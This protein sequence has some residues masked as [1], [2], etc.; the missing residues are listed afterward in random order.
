MQV[1]SITN[2]NNI[3]S[4]LNLSQISNNNENQDSINLKI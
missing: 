3:E 1:I 4:P 2:A